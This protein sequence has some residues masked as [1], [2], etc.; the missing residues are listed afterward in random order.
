MQIVVTV[1]EKALREKVSYETYV[2]ETVLKQ[3]PKQLPV[4]VNAT[5]SADIGKRVYRRI[6]EGGAR[7]EIGTFIIEKYE[8][9]IDE[10]WCLQGYLVFPLT[11]QLDLASNPVFKVLYERCE[12]YKSYAV[13]KIYGIEA[14]FK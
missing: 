13:S 3:L 14:S 4:Y 5:T 12:M 8:Q 2:T 11:K 6:S 10:D 1:V 7:T 9:C